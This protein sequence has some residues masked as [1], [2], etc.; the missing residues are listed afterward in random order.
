[1]GWSSKYQTTNQAPIEWSTEVPVSTPSQPTWQPN[2]G[3]AKRWLLGRPKKF[4]P[5]GVEE[6]IIHYLYIYDIYIYIRYINHMCIYIHIMYIFICHLMFLSG[7]YHG[8]LLGT[9]SDFAPARA[10]AKG[11][12]KGK[13][14]WSIQTTSMLGQSLVVSTVYAYIYTYLYT[15]KF[16]CIYYIYYVCIQ[17][18]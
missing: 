16:L 6:N 9:S 15:H 8:K 11:P 12:R 1:M 2:D 4:T 7:I 18:N 14:E 5:G 13:Q 3:K 10:G 17:I